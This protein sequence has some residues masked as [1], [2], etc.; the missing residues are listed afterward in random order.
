MRIALFATCLADTMFPAAAKATVL[1]LERLGHEV[2]FPPEQTCCGQMHGNTGYEEEGDRLPPRP[3]R[4]FEGAGGHPAGVWGG[5]EPTP[6]SRRPPRAS[7]TCAS[8]ARGS[9]AASSS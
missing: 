7:R 9:T 5:G 1:V 6:S 8:T 3:P 2:V 4:V